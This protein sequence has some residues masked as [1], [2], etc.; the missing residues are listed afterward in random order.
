MPHAID[1][2]TTTRFSPE[3]LQE[4]REAAHL[5]R[6]QVAYSLRRSPQAVYWYET[7]VMGPRVPEMAQKIA[8]VLGVTPDWLFEEGEPSNRLEHAV[9]ELLQAVEEQK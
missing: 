9:D 4:L 5:S 7:G 8:D 6:D 2:S 3:R 1:P